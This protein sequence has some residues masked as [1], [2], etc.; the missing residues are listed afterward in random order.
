M[1]ASRRF[2]LT[3]SLAVLL[4][5]P[6]LA[7]VAWPGNF[8]KAWVCGRVTADGKPLAGARVMAL[9]DS[10]MAMTHSTANGNYS[11]GVGAGKWT[12]T[13]THQGFR[14]Q[15]P[16]E[17]TLKGGQA[18]ETTHLALVA[19]T[20]VV[21]GRVIDEKGRPLPRSAVVAA[22]FMDLE[23]E[24]DGFQGRMPAQAVADAQ[25]RFVLSLE[26]G[27]W[28]VSA[29]RRNYE[30]SPK[31]P[32]LRI[33][34]MPEGMQ[35]NLPG[36]VTRATAEPDAECVVILRPADRQPEETPDTS[37]HDG[38]PVVAQPLVLEGR[39]CLS[40]GN[41]LHWTRTRDR[42]SM[43]GCVVKRSTTPFDGKAPVVEVNQ[44][45]SLMGVLQDGEGSVFSLTD[46]TS[47]S[48]TTYW[49]AVQEVGSKGA[50][51]LSNPVGLTT[52]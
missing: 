47:I 27:T 35:M 44:A 46:T 39:A 31:N 9:G 5:A 51:P 40:P 12:V 24:E 33:P 23:S 15:S 25:G 37:G 3:L 10:G 2:W 19:S 41:V 48:G 32:P 52:R 21:H 13:A 22:P 34:G 1:P 17:V 43:A 36:V 30:M 29:S 45:E 49:Y 38:K 28:L 14:L 7:Q 42:K 18:N 20:A 26:Q 8:Q 50:G 4:A 16:A 6:L 11:L